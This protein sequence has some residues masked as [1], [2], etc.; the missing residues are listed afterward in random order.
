MIA[1]HF[2]LAFTLAGA[3]AVALGYEKDKA[4]YLAVFAG[5]FSIIPDVDMIYGIKGVVLA[6]ESG[7]G[8]FPGTFWTVSNR[9]HRGL[10]HSLVTGLAASIGFTA[11]FIRNK[12]SVASAVTGLLVATAFVFEDFVGAVVMLAFSVIGLALAEK[13]QGKMS[14]KEFFSIASLGLLS[15]PFGDFFTGTP[16]EL[17]FPLTNAVKESRIVLNQDPVL[18]LLSIFGLEL[19]LGLSALILG[20]YLKEIPVKEKISPLVALGGLYGF[21]FYL[22]PA[23]TLAASYS[24]VFSILGYGVVVPAY[25]FKSMKKDIEDLLT[26]GLNYVLTI[27]VALAT[28]ILIYVVA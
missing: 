3:I 23:P 19:S 11:Y 2:L 6:L 4:L 20:L 27:A 15:H 13:A 22:I 25:H 18:N 10:S 12:I 14:S 1:G 5:G 24:F 21:A 26:V 9:V 28:Y 7:P 16:P 17:F 8:G